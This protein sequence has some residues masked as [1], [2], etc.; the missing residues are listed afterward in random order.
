MEEN[1][2][3]GK[4]RCNYLNNLLRRIMKNYAPEDYIPAEVLIPSIFPDLYKNFLDKM[5]EEH[6]KGFIEGRNS[7]LE[8]DK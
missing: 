2:S 4:V 3:L 5:K 7:I 6:T 8:E 1:T